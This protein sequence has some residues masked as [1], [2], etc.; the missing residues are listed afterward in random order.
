M[1]RIATT[2]CVGLAMTLYPSYCFYPQRRHA[3]REDGFSV[4][5]SLSRDN[6]KAFLALFALGNSAEFQQKAFP[7]SV[8]FFPKKRD[9][10]H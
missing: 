1:E 8:A 5:R 10:K 3:R 6:G 9:G 7:I 4:K 2:H